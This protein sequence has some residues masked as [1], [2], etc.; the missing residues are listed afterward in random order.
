[1]VRVACAFWY[2][3]GPGTAIE[4]AFVQVD[5]TLPFGGSERGRAD[6]ACASPGIERNK[7]ELGD[8]LP[9]PPI[10]GLPLLHFSEYPS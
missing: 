10:C 5:P 4:D 3:V 6:R 2:H 8:V 9:A 1:M 7:D